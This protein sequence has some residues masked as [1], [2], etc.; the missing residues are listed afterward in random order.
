MTGRGRVGGLLAAILLVLPASVRAVSGDLPA[1]RGELTLAATLHLPETDGPHPI[2]LIVHGSGSSGRSNVWT[3]AWAE[4]LVARGCAVLHPDKRG[5]G[6]SGGDWKTATFDDLADDVLAHVD[7][8][9]ERPEIDADRI[10]LLGFSQ[11]SYI[12]PIAA[13]R[14]EDVD[15]VVSVSGSVVP[16]HEQ[17]A[18]EVRLIARGEGLD[19]AAIDEVLNVNELALHWARSEDGWAEYEAALETLRAGP[20][21]DTQA[22][23]GFP[24][25]K[26][27]WVWPWVAGIVDVDPLPYWKRLDRPMLFVFGGRDDNV[28]AGKSVA[29]IEKELIDENACVLW[30]G[31]NGHGL[32]RDDVADFLVCWI[33][34]G[35]AR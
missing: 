3:T 7:T 5:A 26:D 31:P 19:A 27:L 15:L 29:R 21:G 4:A 30:M 28:D 25:E 10:V 13:G 20:L 22:A 12:A 17:L 2:V 18:D 33:R 16:M 8:I 1:T 14:S 11:G 34:D 32:I 23:G 9:R 6:E 35:G 24:S